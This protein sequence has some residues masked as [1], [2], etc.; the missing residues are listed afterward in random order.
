MS[1]TVT[2]YQPHYY[3]RLHYFARIKQADIFVIYD[4]VEFS[5]R[6]RQHR[7]PIDLSDKGWLTI[8][9]RHTSSDVRIDEARIDMSEPWP[10]DHV[11]TLRRE[12]GAAVDEFRPFYER[13]CA[14][15]VEIETLRRCRDEIARYAERDLVNECLRLNDELRARRR[16]YQLPEL[17]ERKTR[18]ADRIT[19]RRHADP[20]ADIDDLVAESK[21][22]QTKLVEAEAACRSLR[23]RCN[24]T[25]V[26]LAASLP[27]ERDIA[28]VSMARL[29]N[30]DG[31]DPGELMADVRLVDLT[32]PLLNELLSRLD[33]ESTVVRSSQLPVTH[34]GDPSAYLARLTDYLGGDNYLTGG[35][36]YENYLDETPFEKR[37][38]TVCVQDWTPT[39]KDGNVCALDIL[40][41]TEQPGA[42]LA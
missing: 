12:Y 33:I 3:P 30:L 42:V 40:Y 18:L 38:Q 8:P 6:S 25:L 9:V 31:V 34:P 27:A 14:D 36:G 39:W 2:A 35:V 32:V 22:V 1:R 37:G 11:K 10:V 20:T 24:R 28:D 19:K 29:W 16:E 41:D 26:T 7:T 5:R 17:R 13:L 21:A 4:D 23:E 15:F